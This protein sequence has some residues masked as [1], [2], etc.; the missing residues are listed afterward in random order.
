M[1]KTVFLVR[2]RDT[3]LS[4]LLPNLRP[5]RDG[6]PQ[7]NPRIPSYSA[8]QLIQAVAE[9]PGTDVT[10]PNAFAVPL[11]SPTNVLSWLR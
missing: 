4:D 5:M 10:L 9:L 11:A 6:Y 8:I 1:L 7:A 3:G 2:N